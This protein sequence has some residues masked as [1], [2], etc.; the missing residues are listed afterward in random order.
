MC[1]DADLLHKFAFGA[2]AID[3]LIAF[4]QAP[5]SLIAV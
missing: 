4:K 2:T 5:S 3:L 1:D